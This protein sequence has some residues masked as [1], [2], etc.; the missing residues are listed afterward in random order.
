MAFVLRAV[1]LTKTFVP[2]TLHGASA[3][4][5]SPLVLGNCLFRVL[6]VN[7]AL[8]NTVQARRQNR[9]S[10]LCTLAANILSLV[11]QCTY[12]SLFGVKFSDPVQGYLQNHTESENGRGWKGPLWVTQSN[13]PAE[14][15]S[16]RAGCTGPRPGG[17]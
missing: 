13:P 6:R 4:R 9:S 12:A 7:I 15:G 16:P 14:A 11:L 8:E 2:L 17:S 10:S 5:G 1:S 3:S